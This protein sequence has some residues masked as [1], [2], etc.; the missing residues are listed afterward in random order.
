MLVVTLLVVMVMVVVVVAMAMVIVMGV[1]AMVM[2]MVVVRGVVAAE[3]G[4][5]RLSRQ[6]HREHMSWR[7]GELEGE[8]SG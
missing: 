4:Y 6:V 7:E 2:M 8:V 3:S 5:V 1:M